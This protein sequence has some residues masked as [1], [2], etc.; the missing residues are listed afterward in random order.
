MANFLK[1]DAHIVGVII[2]LLV[3]LISYGLLL[4]L[5][6]LIVTLFKLDVFMR[7]EVIR[8]IAI[9]VNALPLR[10][11]FVTTKQEQTGRGILFV[12]L[13][14]AVVYFSMY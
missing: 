14:Y 4:L 8:L 9:F 7:D 1:K 10:Y 2:G 3:P 12:F 6:Y 11:Y 13:I 5:N